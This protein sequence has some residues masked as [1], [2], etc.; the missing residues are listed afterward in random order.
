MLMPDWAFLSAFWHP[1]M[2]IAQIYAAWIGPCCMIKSVQGVHVHAAYLHVYPYVQKYVS[3]VYVYVYMYIYIYMYVYIIY[4][5]I[6]IYIP[7]HI[8][9]YKC[10]PFLY[11]VSP[12]LE[13]KEITMLEQVGYRTKPMQSGMF[14]VRYQTKILDADASVCFLDADAELC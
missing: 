10:W 1:C 5:Y 3:R 11:P 6:H 2:S 12:V 8:Y 4:T 9:I 14:G 7:V 13:W